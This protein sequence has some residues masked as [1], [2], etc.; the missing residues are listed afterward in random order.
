MTMGANL[1]DS[2]RRLSSSPDC[3]LT[4]RGGRR[5][6]GALEAR[7][8]A[9]DPIGRMAWRSPAPQGAA[10]RAWHNGPPTMLGR[11]SIYNY[12]NNC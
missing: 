10:V 3:G 6:P 4:L 7:A 5:Q 1:R 8:R 2:A 9:A 11:Y 12:D